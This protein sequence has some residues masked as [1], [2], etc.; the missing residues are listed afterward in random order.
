MIRL[1]HVSKSFDNNQSLIV[2]D[3]SFTIEKGETLV[4][5]GS[6]GAGKSTVLKM[7]NRLI[8]LSK[9][10]IEV[11]GRSINTY[12]PVE[13][14]RALGYVFQDIGL[15]PHLT[16]AEN[17]SIVLRLTKQ[18]KSKQKQRACELLELVGLNPDQYADRY[19]A[20]LSGGQQQRVGV[21]R[22]LAADPDYLLM[23]EPFGALDA[24]TRA[25]LQ[26]EILRLKKELNKT[27]LFVTHDIFEALRLADRLAVMHNGKLEQV[28][29]KEE[30]I[31]K[32]ATPFV[33]ELLHNTAEQIHTYAK[34]F[35]H[36]DDV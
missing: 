3:V 31:H 17:I 10:D 36:Q 1:S 4:L 14:R 8:P 19:P 2:Q 25:D 22:A 12:H 23:D 15:F 24:I 35:N 32:P 26:Y 29:R 6:S 27:I 5:L 7:I 18:S 11:D 30:L 34:Y 16:I 33:Q 28:G 21:A 20:E 13:L 9:G